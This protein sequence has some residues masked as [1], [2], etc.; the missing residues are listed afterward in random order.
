MIRM[1]TPF[2]AQSL[3]CSLHFHA[4]ADQLSLKLLQNTVKLGSGCQ[5]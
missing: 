1:S 4:G 3:H 5:P 2:V